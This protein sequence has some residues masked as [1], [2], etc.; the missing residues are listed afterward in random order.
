MTCFVEFAVVRYEYFRHHRDDFSPVHG[1]GAG[2]EPVAEAYRC[3]D[4]GK[5]VTR[6]FGCGDERGF[7]CVKQRIAAEQVAAGVAG[8][9]KLG[10][11]KHFRSVLLRFTY[12]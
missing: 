2:I 1:N 9:A 11:G 7:G 3:A 5:Q 4:K 12:H 6:V 10:Q 8:Y